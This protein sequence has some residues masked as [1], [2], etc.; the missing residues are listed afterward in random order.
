M[1]VELSIQDLVLIERAAL[2]FERGLNV[3]TGETGAGK[4]LLIDALEFLLGERARS[5]L[6][7]QG[8][9]Q[10]RV[11]G[12]FRLELSGYGERVATWL[13]EHLP[14]TLLDKTDDE[15]AL[16]LILTRSLTPDGRSSAHVNHR[17]I[18]QRMLRELAS[19]LVEI[20]GQNDHQRLLDAGEQLSLLDTFGGLDA[21]TGDYEQGRRRFLALA[22]RL[23][24][25]TASEAERG[26]RLDFLRFQA[27]ELR[28]LAPSAEE[29]P[30]L[31]AERQML[32]HAEE[33]RQQLGALLHELGE[34]EQAALDQVRRAERVVSDWQQEVSAL[35][36]AALK[37]GESLVHLEEAV[38]TLAQFASRIDGNPERLAE[39]EE[40]LAALHEAE[41]KYRTD[42]AGLVSRLA[43]I[44]AEIAALEA[45]AQGAGELGA[46][47][48]K[49]RDA[50]AT[51]DGELLEARK[52][53]ARKL[54]RAVL[55]SFKDLGLERAE[56]TV[57][58]APRDPESS[59]DQD[60]LAAD[61][62]RF[63]PRGSADVEFLLAA[64]PGEPVQPLRTVASGGEMARIMLALRGALAVRQTVPT[65][66]FDEVDAGVGGRLGPRV[67]AHLAALAKHHQ[68]L[69]VTH[70]PA[71]AAL[72]QQHCRV[73]KD[74]HRGR[75]RTHI[76]ELTGDDRVNEIAD[77]I[78]GGAAHETA[79]AEARRLL[80]DPG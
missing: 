50:L 42:V 43:E 24:D 46:A 1:L 13:R 49:A 74:Q 16:E 72:A 64:N 3:F 8:A 56:F 52:G 51:H 57:T 4:S 79:R 63:G 11:E 7:R 14:E 18:T 19:Q 68:I 71:I 38:A 62:H 33:L 59:G 78:A 20:H 58:F 41:R 23:R 73:H 53:A 65:L 55:K 9:T 28:A 44:E 54:E 15:Q 17:A 75:T 66:I 45:E 60:A 32:R 34:S 21:K 31:S 30:A 2:R 70:L 61:Q 40:R 77:M 22:E 10:A 27:S 12:R 5:G 35:S 25:A 6:V 76:A 48:E 36:P 47:I 37:L 69:C 39:V 80:A 67:G 26:Q 29:K